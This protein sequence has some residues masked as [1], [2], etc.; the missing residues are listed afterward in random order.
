MLFY[1]RAY[2][3][4]ISFRFPWWLWTEISVGHEALQLFITMLANRSA[5]PVPATGCWH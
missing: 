2:L 1:L 3:Y 4:F 5:S